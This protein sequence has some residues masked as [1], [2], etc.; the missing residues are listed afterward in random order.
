MNGILITP[1]SISSK[2]HPLFSSLEAMGYEII[3]PTP[4]AMPSEE[5]LIRHIPTCVAYLAGVEPVTEKVLRAAKYLKVISRNGAGLDN[6]DLKIASELGIQV[7]GAPGANAQG[8]AELALGL[9]LSGMRHVVWHDHT[10]RDG[11]WSRTIGFEAQGKRLGIIGCGNIGQRLARMAIGVGFEVWGYDPYPS[12]EMKAL[13]GFSYHS[14]E[15]VLAESDV[16]SLHCPPEGKPLLDS[17]TLARTK[18]GVLIVNTARDA[19][20]DHQAM[21][22]A[23]KAEHVGLF[24]TD[25]F[26]TEPPVLDELLQHPK[27]VI[28]PHIGGFTKES[29]ERATVASVQN[30]IDILQKEQK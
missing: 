8:V 5:D 2:G 22:D 25:V 26:E 11:G 12:E 23:L 27:V 14:R 18:R 7:L 3:C 6:V 20:I 19:L 24:A 17:E 16:L 29:V 10:L 21:L 13:P 1:R 9:L 4:G 30:I 15:D 28:T